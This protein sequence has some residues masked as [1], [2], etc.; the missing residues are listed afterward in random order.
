[1]I[2]ETIIKVGPEYI[3]IWW[4]A[5]IEPKDKEILA[6]N[7]SKE[8]NMFVAEYFLSNIVDEHGKHP[9]STDMVVI[10]IRKPVDS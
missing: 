5:I 4:V 2:D 3:W 1:M 6:T 8:Q 9:I 7:I 10:G